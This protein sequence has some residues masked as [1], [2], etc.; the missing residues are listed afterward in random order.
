MWPDERLAILRSQRIRP[1][2]GLVHH[3]SGP[4]HT[5]LLQPG[6]AEGLARYAFEVAKR[7]P[8]IED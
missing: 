7:Y 8:W 1:I 5:D 6:F 3:G 4:L 2:V